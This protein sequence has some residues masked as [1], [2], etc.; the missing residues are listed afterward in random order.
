MSEQVRPWHELS[1]EE[2]A[3]EAERVGA[4][5]VT[6]VEVADV[7][8]EEWAVWEDSGDHDPE[9]DHRE[10]VDVHQDEQPGGAL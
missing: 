8:A 9:D 4:G 7:P 1:A 3:A 10:G 6:S 2:Q 5:H